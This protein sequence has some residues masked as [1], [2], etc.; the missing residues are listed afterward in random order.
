MPNIETAVGFIDR[1]EELIKKNGVERRSLTEDEK[2][3]LYQVSIMLEADSIFILFLKSFL[4]IY[5]SVNEQGRM[6][7]A[8]LLRRLTKEI[9]GNN[10]LRI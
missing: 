1:I 8:I 9:N 2:I 6:L 4:Q 10:N 5:Q 3:Q 7:L